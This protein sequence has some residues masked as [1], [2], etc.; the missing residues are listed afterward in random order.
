MRLAHEHAMRCEGEG[1]EE[2]MQGVHGESVTTEASRPPPL[3]MARARMRP[4]AGV[5]SQTQRPGEGG[6]ARLPA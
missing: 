4:S 3:E 5:S 6:E 2:R 1:V